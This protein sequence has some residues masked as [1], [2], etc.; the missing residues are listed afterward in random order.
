[1]SRTRE[2]SAAGQTVRWKAVEADS[3]GARALDVAATWR[4]A[5]YG[6]SNA[7]YTVKD[8]L[9]NVLLTAD[10]DQRVNPNDFE[11]DGYDCSYGGGGLDEIFQ[12]TV[13]A[14]GVWQLDTMTICANWDTSLM[15][16][17]ETGGGCPGDFHD[18]DGDSGAC[19][20]G[21]SGGRPPR[22]PRSTSPGP[23]ANA[24]CST[25]ITGTP[26][27]TR[28]RTG[29]RHSPSGCGRGTTGASGTRV[30]RP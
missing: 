29:P 30:G 20:S 24:T 27:R 3:S 28:T 23:T 7:T 17:E 14:T 6:A 4:G 21:F 18:C 1:M 11:N 19:G 22:I 8:D 25:W 12:F 9:G 2:R 16:R 13:D 15:V 10:V 5:R 26:S